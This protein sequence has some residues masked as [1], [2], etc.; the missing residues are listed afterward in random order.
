MVIFS[1]FYIDG[2]SEFLKKI[3][4]AL[5]IFSVFIIL[6]VAMSGLPSGMYSGCNLNK[7][8]SYSQVKSIYTKGNFAP[9]ILKY[10][11]TGESI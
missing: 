8:G 7:F 4:K 5:V 6:S 9:V 10:L 3:Y 1:G 11:F 2:V